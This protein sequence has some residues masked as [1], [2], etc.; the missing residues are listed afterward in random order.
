M[1]N[2][3][4]FPVTGMA[5]PES[6]CHTLVFTLYEG[7]VTHWKT[8]HNSYV[9]IYNCQMCGRQYKRRTDANRQVH[10]SGISVNRV[11]NRDYIPAQGEIP[12]KPPAV[13]STPSSE[14]V[15]SPVD[16]QQARIE[17]QADRQR[18]REEAERGPAVAM[19]N[20]YIDSVFPEDRF[21]LMSAEPEVSDYE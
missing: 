16:R 9:E 21:T 8:I 15:T 7:L 12:R 5:C 17:A 1:S 2:C 19:T 18:I 20:R 14:E 3:I 13:T 6:R 11:R 4:L 10:N